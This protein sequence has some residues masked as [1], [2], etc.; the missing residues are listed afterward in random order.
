MLRVAKRTHMSHRPNAYMHRPRNARSVP[1]A[2]PGWLRLLRESDEALQ[3]V[4]D[5]KLHFREQA[6]IN[7]VPHCLKL[8]RLLVLQAVHAEQRSKRIPH[9]HATSCLC[10]LSLGSSWHPRLLYGLWGLFTVQV[11][12]TSQTLYQSPRTGKRTSATTQAVARGLHPNCR[13]QDD[14]TKRDE[15][16]WHFEHSVEGEVRQDALV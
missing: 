4:P 15:G 2:A 5:L 11:G 16:P 14:I 10:S 7:V 12:C 3:R 8:L 9:V 1:E 13:A 6:D